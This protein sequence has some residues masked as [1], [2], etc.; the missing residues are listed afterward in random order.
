[1]KLNEVKCQVIAIV[2]G[3]SEYVICKN[4]CSNL[5]IK[6]KIYSD[7]KGGK[8]IQIGGLNKTLNNAHF[9][10]IN[11]FK[12]YYDEVEFK[13]NVPVNLKLFIIMDVDDCTEEEKQSFITGKMFSNH[14]LSKWIIPIY[15]NPNLE[16][17]ME[18]AG[19]NIIHKKDYFEIFK[20]NHGNLNVNDVEKLCADLTKCSCTNIDM[21]LDYCLSLVSKA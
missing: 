12:Q 14:W 20:P 2:H 7:K 16:K 9:R 3:K 1:M 11:G 6:H 15:N 19:I 17:T 8:S 13:R 4:I 5:R 18:E 21:F 10:D